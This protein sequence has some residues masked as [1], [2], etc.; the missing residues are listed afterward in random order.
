MSRLALYVAKCS[1]AGASVRGLGALHAVFLVSLPPDV[2]VCVVCWAEVYFKVGPESVTKYLAR[3]MRPF[4]PGPR[5]PLRGYWRVP[6]EVLADRDVAAEWA[7]RAADTARRYGRR[8][9]TALRRR[10]RGAC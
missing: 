5:Q 1:G 6:P 10:G 3:G 4:R 9:R 2:P 8:R 7:A